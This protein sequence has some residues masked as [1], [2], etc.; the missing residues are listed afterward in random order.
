[1]L[2]SFR[3][4]YPESHILAGSENVIIRL[5]LIREGVKMSEKKNENWKD[6]H[7]GEPSRIVSYY[8]YYVGNQ[9]VRNCM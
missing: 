7:D 2:T 3:I 4:Y 6:G 5:K 8:S 1:M 9:F